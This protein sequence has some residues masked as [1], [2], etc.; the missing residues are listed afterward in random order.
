MIQLDFKCILSA[1]YRDLGLDTTVY[2]DLQSQI[3]DQSLETFLKTGSEVCAQIRTG[4]IPCNSRDA[5]R[6]FQYLSVF[7]KMPGAKH[8]ERVKNDL[9]NRQSSIG[10]VHFRKG[11]KEALTRYVSYVLGSRDPVEDIY[12][13]VQHGPGATAE[14]ALYD[15]K[16]FAF[17]TIPPSLVGL[18]RKF[19]L[20]NRLGDPT[21]TDYPS[22]VIVVD[23]DYRGGRVIAAE[24]CSRQFMQQGIGRL[25]K[26][27]LERRGLDLADNAQHIAF[28]T[29]NLDTSCT[30]DLSSASDFVACRHIA[31][32]FPRP[33][34]RPMFASRSAFLS[35][36]GVRIKTRTLASM[37]NGY[38]FTSLTTICAAACAVATNCFVPYK[39]WSVWGDDIIIHHRWFHALLKILAELGF[40]VNYDKSY[41]TASPFA[42]TCGTDIWRDDGANVRPKF[43]RC[44]WSF[45]RKDIGSLEKLLS[46]QRYAERHYLLECSSYLRGLVGRIPT[47]DAS[48]DIPG[49]AC[50][51]GSRNQFKVRYSNR[52]Q[53]LEVRALSASVPK[54]FAELDEGGCWAKWAFSG[55]FTTSKDHPGAALEI[56]SRDSRPCFKWQ[57]LDSFKLGV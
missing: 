8:E 9:I 39:V 13:H 27:R 7:N 10:H 19:D 54:R 55:R 26:D 37:G 41:D 36:D 23:K 47:H 32:T 43:L 51:L 3:N 31:S 11:T 44:P 1:L 57:G 12:R 24:Q 6:I 2:P 28:L 22:R 34:V 52:Y 30:I 49:Y 33:W 46:F 20:L 50:D 53:R 15:D 4:S 18:Y 5:S 48:Y 17:R 42:E 45:K 16:Y 21:I 35:V 29:D 38:C 56:L 25:M 40:V 14:R